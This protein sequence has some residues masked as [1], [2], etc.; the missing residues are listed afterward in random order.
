MVE[1]LWWA[2]TSL[3]ATTITLPDNYPN[4]CGSKQDHFFIFWINAY[5]LQQFDLK[6]VHFSGRSSVNYHV[7]E[8]RSRLS[9]TLDQIL[10]DN[11]A[12]PY[13]I[14]FMETRTAEHL[15]RFWFEAE[16]FRSISWSR[17]RAH[18][19]NS[20][21]QS[22]LAEPATA[23]GSLD[24]PDSPYDAA[25]T[26]AVDED[27]GEDPFLSRTPSRPLTPSPQDTNSHTG[28]LMGHRNS[29][30]SEGSARPGTPRLQ[31][32]LRSE[33]PTR[34]STSRTGTP[35]KGQTTGGLRELSDKLMKSEYLLI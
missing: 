31:P 15:V 17:V 19:L 4:P 11:V 20:V 1:T 16:S 25:S 10:R 26:L 22:T 27:D 13:F 18:S 28:A 32:P 24:S 33:T 21:K 5:V 14:Q 6:S 23:S 2:Y 7:Q 34:Q 29:I 3:I 12:M 9:K 8:T 35:V 30:S